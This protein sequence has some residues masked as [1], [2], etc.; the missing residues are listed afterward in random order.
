V[1][2]IRLGQLRR[3]IR[4]SLKEAGG[5]TTIPPRPVVNNPMS[6]S[7]ADREQLGRISTKDMDDPDEVSPHLRD[8][9]YDEEDCWGPVPPKGANPYSMPDPYTK[10]YHVIPTPQIKR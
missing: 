2:K 6:P 4:Q 1:V 5:G 8:P 7:M 3:I 10:D 9:V